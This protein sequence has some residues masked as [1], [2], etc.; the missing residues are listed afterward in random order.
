[1]VLRR[2]SSP[3]HL[4]LSPFPCP[5]LRKDP[6]CLL[7]KSVLTKDNFESDVGVIL[8]LET[9]VSRLTVT[10]SRHSPAS[11]VISWISPLR[12]VLLN[13]CS[14]SEETVESGGRWP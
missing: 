5:W 7:V 14:Q 9:Q 8:S 3:L 12:L 1:M 6:I 4:R 2:R 11:R 10:I 13:V